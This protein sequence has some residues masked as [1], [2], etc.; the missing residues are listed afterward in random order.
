[1]DPIIRAVLES[2]VAAKERSIGGREV[3]VAMP[4]RSALEAIHGAEA[5]QSATDEGLIVNW[6]AR[7]V[8]AI[9]LTPLGAERMGVVIEER[10]VVVDDVDVD[11]PELPLGTRS[12]QHDPYWSSPDRDHR[13]YR[14]P[15]GW[16]Q[17]ADLPF[18]A[19]P[20]PLPPV[21]DQVIEQE[22]IMGVPVKQV[23]KIHG[24]RKRAVA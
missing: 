13:G 12:L 6:L 15:T 18:A 11:V 16:R 23:A 21:I 8:D 5:I 10:T 3:L 22:Y 24:R 14:L 20:D 9:T 17:F 1:M 2:I 19:I 7:D 4:D